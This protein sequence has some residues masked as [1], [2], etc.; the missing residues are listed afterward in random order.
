MDSPGRPDGT[1]EDRRQGAGARSRL[2]DAS[3][4]GD[5][6]P[7]QDR[8]EILV[9]ERLGLSV[10]R[11]A[12]VA[13]GRAEDQDRRCADS[14]DPTERRP[15]GFAREHAE[16]GDGDHVSCQ[17]DEPLRPAT[18][19]DDDRIEPLR[20]RRPF[21][22]A[23]D[24]RELLY[25]E[26]RFRVR[27]REEERGVVV[28][29]LF[30][31]L[32]QASIVILG[33]IG[34]NLLYGVKKF[35]NFAHGDMMTLGAYFTF[36]FL[37]GTRD[38]MTAAIWA[39]FVVALAGVVQEVLIY[40]RL[41]NRGPVAP[42][43]ASIGVSLVMQNS[44]T[45]YFGPAFL[46]YGIRYPDNWVFFGGAVSTNPIRDLVPMAVAASATTATVVLLKYTKLGKAMR[47]TA[48][49]RDLARVSGVNTRVVYWMTWI[50]AGVLASLSGSVLGVSIGTLA[51]SMGA[52]LLLTMFAAVIVGGIGSTTGAILGSLVVGLSQSLFFLV[53]LVSGLDPRWQ[54]A[55]P[56]ALLVATLLV[57]PTG[58]VGRPIGGE[59]RPLRTEIAEMLKGI[60][61]GL[62]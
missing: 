25:A 54:I 57:K 48:D 20:R 50:L 8:R 53:S 7:I 38:L 3:A 31:G 60:R 39:V 51:P 47:A 5:V 35:A 36:V 11:L 46:S 6:D 9:R 2:E 16:A 28:Q 40:A 49:N 61:R 45:T 41:E 30:N 21:A 33:A 27:Q 18:I 15:Q 23:F 29:F 56:F 52:T 37:G 55:V 19:Q 26:F 4:W 1:G 43:V 34:I 44:L 17:R 58:L 59:I 32:V 10:H 22:H 14:D 62:F 42:L 12:Q 13:D 24:I